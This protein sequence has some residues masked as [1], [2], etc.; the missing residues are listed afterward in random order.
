MLTLLYERSQ[1]L[2]KNVCLLGTMNTIDFM[3]IGKYSFEVP[4]NRVMRR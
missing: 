4:S 3:K 2:E 1:C